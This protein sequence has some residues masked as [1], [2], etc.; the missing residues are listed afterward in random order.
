[1]KKNGVLNSQI[2]AVLADMGHLDTVAIGDAGMPVP[3]NCKKIDLCVTMGEPK[4]ITVLE[5]VLTELKV[6]H[7]Y[8]AE[9]IK[10]EN[11]QQKAAISVLLPDVTATYIPHSEIKKRLGS[12]RNKAFIRTGEDTPYSNIILESGVIF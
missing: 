9:E 10:K 3:P 8:L 1:M 6:Q 2:A 4:F 7:I 5:N 12:S 11:P